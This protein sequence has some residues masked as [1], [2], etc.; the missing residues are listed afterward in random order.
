M[1]CAVEIGSAAIIYILRFI[2]IGSRIQN[3]MGV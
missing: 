1:K 3:L 2:K